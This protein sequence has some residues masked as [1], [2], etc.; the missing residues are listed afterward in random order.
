METILALLNKATRN[1]GSLIH[2]V[3]NGIRADQWSLGN[4]FNTMR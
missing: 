1:K 3:S 2:N 4:Q